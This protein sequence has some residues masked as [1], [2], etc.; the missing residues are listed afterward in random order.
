MPTLLQGSYSVF[1]MAWVI[2][3]YTAAE[4]NVI[5]IPIFFSQP[6]SF[7]AFIFKNLQHFC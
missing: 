5:M 1:P 4:H 3:K 2:H 7:P 6:L